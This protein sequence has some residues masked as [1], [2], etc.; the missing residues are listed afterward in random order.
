MGEIELAIQEQD[1]AIRLDPNSVNA[2]NA[3]G[4]HYM[5]VGEF[6]WALQD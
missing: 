4:T 5:E 6:T 3:Q 1:V 2:Y